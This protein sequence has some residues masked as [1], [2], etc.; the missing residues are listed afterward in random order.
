MNG[1]ETLQVTLDK[2]IP[3]LIV[4]ATAVVLGSGEVRFFDDIYKQDAR[5]EL[6]LA[7]SAH[8]R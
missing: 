3:V 6:A 5:L 4:Y 1:A 7:K 2:P 8:S